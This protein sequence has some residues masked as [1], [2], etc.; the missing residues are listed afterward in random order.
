MKVQ[1][2]KSQLE[3]AAV[4]FWFSGSLETRPLFRGLVSRLVQWMKGQPRTVN[5]YLFKCHV[6]LLYIAI[7]FRVCVC[8]GYG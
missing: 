7:V 8:V 1:L 6:K 4:L 5:S 3:G 2:D